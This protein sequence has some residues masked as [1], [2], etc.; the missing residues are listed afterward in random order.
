MKYT[1]KLNTEN[2]ESIQKHILSEDM[3]FLMPDRKYAG[4]QFMRCTM[5]RSLNIYNNLQGT[6]RKVFL[7]TFYR[8]QPKF[9]K[10]Q[11]HI[12]LRQSCCEKCLN[13]DNILKQA[14]KYS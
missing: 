11:G 8:Y 2:I 10:L 12:P 4:K 7:S 3:S 13:F 9:V 1:H 6:K 14:S 5:R